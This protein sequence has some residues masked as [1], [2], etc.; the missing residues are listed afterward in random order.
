A[1]T[2]RATSPRWNP[3]A[4]KR[5]VVTRSG[6]VPEHADFF[7]GE[8]FVATSG[9]ASVKLPA[10]ARL[11]RAGGSEVD[12]R[13]L[14]ERLRSMG[15]EKLLVMGGSELNAQLLRADLVDELFLT[16]AP[17]VRLGR[18]IPT[19]ADG[20]AL[21]RACI[22]NYDLVEHHVVGG[23]IFLRYRRIEE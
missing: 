20:E 12:F 7:K 4:A 1:G 21:P 9:S 13:L 23:E 10:G 17:K 16:V 2:L 15:V 5:I 19:Y 6:E 8:S 3:G 14:F 18:D 22:Q 11:I